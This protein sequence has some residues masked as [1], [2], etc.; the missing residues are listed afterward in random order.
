M[1][2]IIARQLIGA[3]SL[4]VANAYAYAQEAHTHGAAAAPAPAAGGWAWRS[5]PELAKGRDHHTTVLVEGPSGASLFVAG[6]TDYADAFS[7]VWRLRLRRD[8]SM[9]AWEAPAPGGGAGRATFG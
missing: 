1:Q 6:G 8:G 4:C 9:G 5:G 2:A 7:D 3:G